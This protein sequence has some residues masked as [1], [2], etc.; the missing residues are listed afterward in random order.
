MEG[1]ASVGE[2]AEVTT[3][4]DPISEEDIRWR[5]LFEGDGTLG[6]RLNGYGGVFPRRRS[7]WSSILISLPEENRSSANE[8]STSVVVAAGYNAVTLTTT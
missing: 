6:W 5:A 8:P 2:G 4:S 3:V 7:L 1:G